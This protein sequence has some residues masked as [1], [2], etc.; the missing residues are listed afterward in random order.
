[1]IF[2]D[3]TLGFR[4]ALQ[5]LQILVF[6]AQVGNRTVLDARVQRKEAADRRIF[7]IV[8]SDAGRLRNTMNKR[9][10]T[11]FLLQGL[12]QGLLLNILRKAE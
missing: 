5:I 12:S 4:R 2:G 7:M 9:V 1:M 8:D 3:L 6:L 10:I 11:L